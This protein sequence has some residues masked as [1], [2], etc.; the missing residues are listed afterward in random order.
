MYSI[1]WSRI[2]PRPSDVEQVE[3][4]ISSAEG[5][6]VGTENS[7]SRRHVAGVDRTVWA[8][9]VTSMLTDISSEMIS[10]ILPMYLVLHLGA[11]PVMFGFVDGIYQGM[12]AIARIA[13]G[14]LGD[15]TQRHKSVAIFGYLLSAVCR[16]LLL[17]AGHAW[18]GIAAAVTLDRV[19]KGI[20]TAPR[21][22]IITR[23]SRASELSTA[24]GVHRTLDAAGAMFGPVVAFGVLSLMPGM[25][26]VLFVISFVFAI[27]GVN[28]ITL[29]VHPRHSADGKDG[30]GSISA[31]TVFG[32]LA[33]PRFRA[34]ACASAL[35]G[36]STISDN[37][38]FLVLQ[39]STGLSATAF[40]LL[41]VATSLATAVFAAPLGRF[42]DR[43]GRRGTLITGYASLALVYLL[44]LLPR[45]PWG[46][47]LGAAIVL[48]GIYYA[49]TDGVLTAMAA[50]VLPKEHAGSG[51]AVLAT[52]A[53]LAR[54]GGSLLFG[55]LWSGF[56]VGPATTFF[57]LAL[58]LAVI[59]ASK[60]LK[61]PKVY[62][63]VV[64][65]G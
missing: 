30:E 61:P 57:L 59:V 51:L 38:V 39:K 10:S 26:D 48:F 8:L 64:L 3:S 18:V 41:F 2:L 33:E 20:R 52:A 54:L 40:P 24:F 28:V 32:L 50:A 14:V 15:R 16:L 42:A 17:A 27:I 56:G 7:S 23:C 62:A 34:L 47:L 65:E 44:L 35:L 37:F 13:A 43:V 55:V 11:S 45:L 22:A 58:L 31:K 53:N 49:A 46:L 6:K 36:V 21:D 9:G 63:P 1:E 60:M 12:A 5:A 25:F 19:G 29:F 4:G